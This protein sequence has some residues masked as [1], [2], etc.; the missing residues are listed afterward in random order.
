MLASVQLN[1]LE[2]LSWTSWKCS[3]GHV[4]KCSAKQVGNAQLDK[5]AMLSHASPCHP[6]TK[7]TKKNQFFFSNSYLIDHENTSLIF[8]IVAMY[9]DIVC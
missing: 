9:S 8:F 7:L 1:K 4:G 3:A 5:L 2:M 6:H